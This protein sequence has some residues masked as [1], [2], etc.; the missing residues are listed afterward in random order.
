MQLVDRRRGFT[1]LELLVVVAIFSIVAA[2]SVPLIAG[3][4]Q[5]AQSD[6][7]GIALAAAIRDA[8]M[9]AIAT[10]WQFQV[11]AYDSTGAVPNAFRIQG[12]N[13]VGG[14]VWP[15]AGTA[16]TPPYYGANQMNEAYTTLWQPPGSGVAKDFAMAQIVVPGGGP[17][18]VTFDSR[19][20]MVG[21]CIP[22]ACQVQVNSGSGLTTLTVSQ[23][24]AVQVVKR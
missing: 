12:A 23:A 18:T 24:G 17:F 7:A 15:V 11:V 4:V 19:G 3:A 14:P 9:R 1:L 2:I 5:R 10:G 16:T 8:R 22:A 13:T 6:G 21:A 20:Q